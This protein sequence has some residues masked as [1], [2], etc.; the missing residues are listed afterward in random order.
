MF[1]S[2]VATNASAWMGSRGFGIALW[3]SDFAAGRVLPL[4]L[5]SVEQNPRDPVSHAYLSLV[6]FQRGNVSAAL[7]HA[8]TA[9]RLHPQELVYRF[10]C[11]RLLSVSRNW[12]EALNE[13]TDALVLDP[14]SW[15]S[16]AAS[17]EAYE[18][19][20]DRKRAASAL[21]MA[22][23]LKPDCVQTRCR[24]GSVLLSQ[25][26][27]NSAAASFD[28]ARELHQR[29]GDTHT[30]THRDP[31]AL[32]DFCEV[33]SNDELA[34]CW[35]NAAVASLSLG[36]VED[37]VRWL[38]AALALSS[39]LKEAMKVSTGS[40]LITPIPTPII[41]FVTRGVAVVRAES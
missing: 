41:C 1:E 15:Q 16:L 18:A 12:N 9:A 7:S 40:S 26:N 34:S 32:P 39:D 33:P 8:R 20:G 28:K 10:L 3:R 22:V 24:L 27:V 36:Y 4:L 30:A 29:G 21:Q 14:A 6:F 37:G 11:G 19:L 17:A 2:A 25:G 13:F 38:E 5:R 31:L 35:N 23:S